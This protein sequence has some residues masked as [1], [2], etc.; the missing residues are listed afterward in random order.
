MGNID[1][2]SINRVLV[3]KLRHIGD[4]LLAVPAIS[5]LKA[6]RPEISVSAL[7]LAGTEDMLTLNPDID[8][9]MTL[10][11]G[12]GILENLR[13]IKRLRRKGFDL[14]INMTEGDRGAILALLSG[15][16]YRIGVDPMGRGFKGKRFFFTH[17]VMPVYDGRHRAVMDMDLLDPL[18]IT[19]KEPRLSLYTSKEDDE[20]VGRLLADNGIAA[21]DAIAVVHPASR[22]MFKCWRDEA[23]AKVMD[24]LA[25]RGMKV[26]MTS[27][28]DE[29]ESDMVRR[30]TWLA[31]RKPL[32]LSGML[33]LKRL[34][35]LLKRSSLFFGV[36]TAPMHMAAAVGVPVVALFGPSNFLVWAPLTDKGRV[37]VKDSEFD[38]IPCEK[39]G[40]NG[41]KKSKCLEAITPEEAIAAIEELLGAADAG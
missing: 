29:R 36:D 30:I 12:M 31:D 13:L 18:G 11:R 17:L 15:A 9:V 25:D 41:T 14:V 38:C 8:E 7:V 20:Y 27:G 19:A 2:G 34:A 40:C 24:Y 22:W 28:P 26:V 33:S 39:D 4:V 3:I 5:A 6:A 35:S 21:G 16:R 23:V 10:S 32:D 37:I 1:L